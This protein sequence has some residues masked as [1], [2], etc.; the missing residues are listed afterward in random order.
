MLHNFKSVYSSAL[1]LEAYMEFVYRWHFF[2]VGEERC[3][4]IL[5]VFFSAKTIQNTNPTI[6]LMA[7]ETSGVILDGWLDGW[8]DG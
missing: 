2:F 4:L 1:T 6:V 7:S 3:Q 5:H 8:L